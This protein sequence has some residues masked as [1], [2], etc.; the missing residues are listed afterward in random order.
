MLVTHGV[1]EI[2]EVIDVDHETGKASRGIAAYTL[3]Q[4]IE[5]APVEDLG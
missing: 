1:V 2:L 5:A 4:H 3:D